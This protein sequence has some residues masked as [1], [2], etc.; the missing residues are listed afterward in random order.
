MSEFDLDP[1]QHTL[2]ANVEALRENE[3]PGRVIAMGKNESGT[4]IFQAYAL[5]GRSEASRNRMFIEDNEGIRTVA[6]DMTEKE[7]ARV[8]MSELIYYRAM[9]GTTANHVVSN[10]AQTDPIFWATLMSEPPAIAM[11][12]APVLNGVDLSEYEPDEPNYTPRIVGIVTDF[13]ETDKR[14]VNTLM[15]GQIYRED[16]ASGDYYTDDRDIEVELFELSSGV[17]Y[18]IQTYAGNGNPLP[19]FK[20]L[21]YPLPFPETREELAHNLWDI[22]N[23]ENRVAVVVKSISIGSGEGTGYSIVQKH[24]AQDSEGPFS[25]GTNVGN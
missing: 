7:M 13:S 25:G 15:W 24:G 10:G 22:L 18:A 1:S 6:P 9:R 4:D 12:D 21:P 3:Y 19:S 14:I 5:T 2:E 11:R 16:S 20:E 23:H 17:G 8:A